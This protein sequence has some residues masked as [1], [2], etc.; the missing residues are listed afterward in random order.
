MSLGGRPIRAVVTHTFMVAPGSRATLTGVALARS[1]LNGRQD[2]CIAEGVGASRRLMEGLGGS[3]S[4]LHSLRWTRPLRPARYLL[5]YFERRG[6][7]AAAGRALAP[8]CA[9]ADALTPAALGALPCPPGNRLTRAPLDSGSWKAGLDDLARLRA[10]RPGYDAAALRWL[11][12]LLDRRRGLGTL[13]RMVVRDREGKAAGWFVYYLRRGGVSEVVQLA[14]DPGATGEVLDHLFEDARQG[15]SVAVRGALD[16]PHFTALVKKG[17]VFHHDGD[18]WF[19]FHS[20]RPGVIDAIL[21]GD[22]F[23]SRLEGEWCLVL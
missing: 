15:G 10:L 22:A 6:L 5:S 11:N 1:L 20:R 14:S 16:P 7:P 3:V 18:R 19:V 23:I 17:C 4:L 8:L 9:A 12:A 2:L 21:R 13:R